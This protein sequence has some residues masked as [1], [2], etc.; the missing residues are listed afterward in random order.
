[1]QKYYKVVT[2]DL[3]S[4]WLGS[5][6]NY[7]TIK[8]TGFSDF[9]IQYKLGEFVKPLAGNLMVFES[10]EMA[11]KWLDIVF[12]F[13]EHSIYECEIKNVVPRDKAFF[14]YTHPQT[15]VESLKEYLQLRKKHRSTKTIETD[16]DDAPDGTVFCRQV[17]LTKL[18]RNVIR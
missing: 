11:E 18:I 10:L 4:A 13:A 8:S 3:K 1:M 12:Y 7:S 5:P 2:K 16:I 6:N 17:K 15:I 9:I 14:V